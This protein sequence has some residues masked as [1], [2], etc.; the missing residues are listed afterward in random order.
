[1]QRQLEVARQHRRREERLA[2]SGS[3]SAP[4]ILEA[5]NELALARE[6]VAHSAEILHDLGLDPDSQQDGLWLKASRAGTVV[7]SQASLGQA[8]TADQALFEI[9]DPGRLWLWIYVHEQDQARVRLGQTVQVEVEALPGHRFTGHLSYLPPQVEL[10]SRALRCRV[11]VDN[12][13]LLLKVGMAAR[14][15][16]ALSAPHQAVTIPPA[17][18]LGENRIFVGN[19]D[20]YEARQ[21]ILGLRRQDWIEVKQGLQPGEAVVTAG[22]DLLGESR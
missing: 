4:R 9:L 15:R 18:L 20:K 8:V 1:S 22:A 11:V 7:S 19:G 21:V 13:E 5:E 3:L 10:P 12:P 6:E 17:A 14:V 2:A 16:L